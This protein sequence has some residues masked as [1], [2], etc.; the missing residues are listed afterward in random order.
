M[1]QEN[2][3]P[4]KNVLLYTMSFLVESH[5]DEPEQ[6]LQG[7]ILTGLRAQVAM[8]EVHILDLKDYCNYAETYE[9]ADEQTD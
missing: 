9:R 2:S 5:T 1:K 3:P 4:N 7:E 6:V 8:C